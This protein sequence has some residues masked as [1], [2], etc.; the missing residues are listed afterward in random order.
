M[1]RKQDDK[2][3]PLKPALVL[4][5]TRRCASALRALSSA[6]FRC[7]STPRARMSSKSTC[8]G[9][10]VI[11]DG[12]MN[13]DDDDDDDD[14]DNDDDDDADDDD[15]DEK[16]YLPEKIWLVRRSDT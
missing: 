15:D 10:I 9:R 3:S 8:K 6:S 12:M 2:L 11:G 1:E 5:N 13:D 7:V 16:V 14:D 4:V